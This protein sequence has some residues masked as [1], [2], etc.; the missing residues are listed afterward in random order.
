MT[1]GCSR[2]PV[3]E[4]VSITDTYSRFSGVFL[5]DEV[6]VDVLRTLKLSQIPRAIPDS[7]IL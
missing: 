7:S 1:S 5:K 4:I 3:L 2:A 6:V